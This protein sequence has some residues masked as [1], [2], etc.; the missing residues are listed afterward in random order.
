MREMKVSVVLFVG[1]FTFPGEDDWNIV[2]VTNTV[3]VFFKPL[4]YKCIVCEG[5]YE[6]GEDFITFR[7]F[8][9]RSGW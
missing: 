9:Q 2:S 4:T 5:K 1:A 6:N 7:L 3:V 8:I